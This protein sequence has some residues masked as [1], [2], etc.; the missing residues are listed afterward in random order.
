[1]LDDE[2]AYAA[3]CRAHNPYDDGRAADQI[4]EVLIRE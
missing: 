1:V 3:M 4:V 2:A